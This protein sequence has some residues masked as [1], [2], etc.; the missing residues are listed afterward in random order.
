MNLQVISLSIS[1]K[2]LLM[3]KI[4]EV[5]LPAWDELR[6]I[7]SSIHSIAVPPVLIVNFFKGQV[8]SSLLELAVREAIICEFRGY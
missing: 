3:A 5:P 8:L 1:L 4:K 7:T 2:E 6:W